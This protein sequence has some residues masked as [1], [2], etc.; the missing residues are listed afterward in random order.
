MVEKRAASTILRRLGYRLTPQRAAIIAAVADARGHIEADAIHRHVA[1]NH[2][3]LSRSTV[4]RALDL[5]D[6]LGFLV[7]HHDATGIAYHHAGDHAHVHLACLACDHVAMLGDDAIAADFVER[8]RDRT[9]FIA[10]LA[11]STLFG[12]CGGCAEAGR[13]PSD[14]HRHDDLDDIH[15]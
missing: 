10:N 15:A 5:L 2:P 12:V 14:H 3:T 9:G 4:Y 11:H 6:R 8:V 7:H 13:S 1:V